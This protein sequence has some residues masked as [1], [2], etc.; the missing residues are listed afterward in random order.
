MPS[1]PRTTV[2]EHAKLPASASKRF[3]EGA[4]GTNHDTDNKLLLKNHVWSYTMSL[5]S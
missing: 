5:A 2:T 3:G 4:E 1:L